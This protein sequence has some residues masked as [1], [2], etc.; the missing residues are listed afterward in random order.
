MSIT[1]NLLSFDP[2]DTGSVGQFFQ[3]GGGTPG[4]DTDIIIAGTQAF[5][6]RVTDTTSPGSGVGPTTTAKD[7]TT[8]G[9]HIGA[10]LW[11]TQVGVLS[12]WAIIISDQN[13]RT[14]INAAYLGRTFSTLDYPAEAGWQRVWI[15]VNNITF[16]LSAG[17]ISLASLQF[18]GI[19]GWFST[20]PG[21]TTP[22]LWID[23]VDYTNGTQ[24]ALIATGTS[25][26]NTFADFI[27]ADIGASNANQYGVFRERNGIYNC[28]GRIALS[29]SAAQ[30]T[31]IDSGFNIAFIPQAYISTDFLGINV[32]L[33]AANTDVQ[34]SNGSIFS[35]GATPSGVTRSGDFIVTGAGSGASLTLTDCSLLDL[36]VITLNS[37]TTVDGGSLRSADITQGSST[38]SNADIITQSASTVATID[39]PTFGTTTGLNNVN[40]RQGGSG[41]AIE[42]T[43]PGS[44]TFTNI[45][46]ADYGGTPGSNLTT[47]TGANDAA[48]L[49]SSGGLV[50]INVSGG[51]SPSVRNVTNITASTTEVVA[52]ANFIIRNI[53]PS[54][55]VRIYDVGADP[56]IELAGVETIGTSTPSNSVVVVDTTEFGTPS[57]PKYTLTYT[58]DQADAP[59]SAAIVVM[60][61]DFQ[62]LRQTIT[63][64]A[65]GVDVPIFQI[66]DRNYI[67]R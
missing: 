12:S 64:D 16:D 11:V 43:T 42:I 7:V 55:E 31:F 59:I 52:S 49:N 19:S 51:N 27:T 39:D 23:K 9:T 37:L 63:L 18:V 25:P 28:L 24:A 56:D 60:N 1:E 67:N 66:D 53:E 8:A 30:T 20:T 62:H 36:R 13:A 17:T 57:N 40:F 33:T 10:W 44:Y 34:L 6:R 14:S 61:F 32:D 58:Y 35:T 54:S 26:T 65:D 29:D 4:L 48:I 22:N 21:G 46:F 47:N 41:H 5:G 45:N 38:I 15:D 50:T 3:G 2:V